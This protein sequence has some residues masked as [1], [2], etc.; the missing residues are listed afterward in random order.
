M[1]LSRRI[2]K[3][4]PQR[5]KR[6][7]KGLLSH[8]RQV[9][10][11]GKALFWSV[12]PFRKV[13]VRGD[14]QFAE[15]S[16]GAIELHGLTRQVRLCDRYHFA[17]TLRNQGSRAWPASGPGQ[18]FLRIR[19]TTAASHGARVL[20]EAIRIPLPGLRPGQWCG[21]EQSYPVP[22][23]T[24]CDVVVEFVVETR[25]GLQLEGE[26]AR[27]ER[28]VSGRD[29]ADSEPGFDYEEVYANLNLDEDYWT[30][31]GPGT[32]EEFE[33]LGDGKCAILKEMGLNAKSKVL[34][35]GCGTGQLARP[36]T[37]VLGPDGLYY[38]TDLA[39]PAI[40]F[41]RRTYRFPQFH[42]LKNEQTTLPIR[43]IEF[44]IIYLGSV[45]THMF[46]EDIRGMLKDLRRLLAPTGCIIVDAFVSPQIADYVG[47][48]QMVE[49]NEPNLHKAFHERG[50]KFEEVS[51]HAWNNHVRRVMYKLTVAQPVA[52]VA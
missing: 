52:K 49:L 32:R 30:I 11:M 24:V 38:G 45:F 46:P 14:F 12:V 17:A 25:T 13:L 26:P 33:A 50:L 31:V 15:G 42:F 47:S 37:K 34:D 22:I 8:A 18:L 7:L 29:A 40:E 28:H 23:N 44:D 48:R 35:V 43:Q 2:K 36:L 3:L 41:C 27:L 16:E 51:S 6:P 4:I 39:G 5:L 20:D 10:R 19:W 21:I 1:V 9:W